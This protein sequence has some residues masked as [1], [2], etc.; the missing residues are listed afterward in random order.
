MSGACGVDDP[1][2]DRVA[3]EEDGAVGPTKPD[4]A[5]EPKKGG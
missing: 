4:D 2:N 5:G 3:E 1:A